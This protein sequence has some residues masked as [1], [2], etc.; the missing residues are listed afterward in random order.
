[1]DN[2]AEYDYREEFPQICLGMHGSLTD[3]D[4]EADALG[5]VWNRT[6]ELLARQ[7]SSLPFPADITQAEIRRAWKLWLQSHHSFFCCFIL[8]S[9]C[10]QHLQKAANNS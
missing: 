7:G 5:K 8:L 6:F 2:E 9:Y 3:F 10:Y 4:T 1:M